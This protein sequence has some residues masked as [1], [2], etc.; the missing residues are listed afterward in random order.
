MI[1]SIYYVGE[2]V[3]TADNATY[4]II[5]ISGD[6]CSWFKIFKVLRTRFE[7]MF[8]HSVLFISEVTYQLNIDHCDLP[9]FVNQIR[10]IVT[11]Y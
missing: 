1:A 4:D 11:V 9:N 5:V 2:C 6:A 3:Q 8:W 10:N 7:W